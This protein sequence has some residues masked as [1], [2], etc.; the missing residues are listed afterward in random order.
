MPTMKKIIR[1]YRFGIT[2]GDPSGIGPEVTVKAVSKLSFRFSSRLVLIGDISILEQAAKITSNL[3]MRFSKFDLEQLPTRG[4]IAVLD[5]KS[6]RRKSPNYGQVSTASGK[7]SASYIEAGVKLC[8]DGSLRGIITA[9]ISKEALHKAGFHYPGHTEMLAKLSKTKD[10]AMMFSS[11]DFS[12]VL[13]STHLPLKKAIGVVKKRKILDMLILINKLLRLK[14]PI[15]VCGLNPHASENGLFGIEEEKEIAP[16]VKS[17]KQLKIN[18]VGPLPADSLFSPKMRGNYSVI[19]AMYH[20]QGLVGIKSAAFGQSANI[21]IGLPFIRTS[22]DHGTA[23]ELAGKG[24]ADESSMIFA[25][26]SAF[27]LA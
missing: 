19:L 18:A 4:K 10:V 27:N 9:P 3:K 8:M 16:A 15:A 21:T 26:K 1:P 17:A 14:K 25:I 13:L 24:I 11:P 20:D 6:L 7:A 2:I 12:V 22:V 5:I 23:M